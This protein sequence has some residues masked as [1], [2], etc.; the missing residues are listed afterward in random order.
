MKTLVDVLCGLPILLV[1]WSPYTHVV[2]CVDEDMF[3]HTKLGKVRLERKRDF[4][5]GYLETSKI[6][7]G[8]PWND[9][10]KQAF[11]SAVGRPNLDPT[12]IPLAAPFRWL[13]RC[14]VIG[15]DFR[16]GYRYVNC[17]TFVVQT[18]RAAGVDLL[19]RGRIPTCFVGIYP[20]DLLRLESV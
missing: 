1:C 17:V 2:Q 6:L 3:V 19:R 7:S 12:T 18:W 8:L 20:S 15:R 9:A 13:Y 10:V 14:G 11:T 16:T 4:A 5:P